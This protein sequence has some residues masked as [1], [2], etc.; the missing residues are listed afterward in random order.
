[1]TDDRSRN[2]SIQSFRKRTTIVVINCY[3]KFHTAVSNTALVKKVKIKGAIRISTNGF[4]PTY[5]LINQWASNLDIG[6]IPSMEWEMEHVKSE[7]K[8]L[9]NEE[10]EFFLS[11]GY[12]R[13]YI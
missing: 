12:Q 11:E 5:L 10:C 1:M 2:E 7:W 13:F 8:E 4:F 3:A 6:K 9:K